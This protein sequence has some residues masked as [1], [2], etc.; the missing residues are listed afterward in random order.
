MPRGL[1]LSIKPASFFL[2]F[3]TT[4]CNFTYSST[5]KMAQNSNTLSDARSPPSEVIKLNERVAA[6]EEREYTLVLEK[7]R[8]KVKHRQLKKSYNRLARRFLL[9]KEKYAAVKEERDRL[10]QD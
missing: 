4:L 3:S 7:Y 2:L 9:L 1:W 5:D 10:A 8:L 6:L